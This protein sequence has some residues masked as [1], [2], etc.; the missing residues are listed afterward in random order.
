MNDDLVAVLED[1]RLGAGQNGKP[2]GYKAWGK[3]LGVMYTSLFRFAKGEGSLGIEALRTLAQV[4]K[5][6][7]DN[8]LIWALARHALGVELPA[9]DN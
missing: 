4:A 9:V 7:E 3:T 8:E 2:M 1:R 5:R 6:N